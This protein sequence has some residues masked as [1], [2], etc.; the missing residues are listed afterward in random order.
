MYG[1]PYYQP[2]YSN[3]DE[4]EHYGILGMKW[5]VRRY[6]NPDGTLTQAGKK[7]YAGATQDQIDTSERRKA[8]VVKAAKT[9]AKAVAVGGIAA[10]SI[11][12]LTSGRPAGAVSLGSKALSQLL[13]SGM[14]SDKLAADLTRDNLAREGTRSL[15]WTLWNNTSPTYKSTGGTLSQ[16]ALAKVIESELK[17]NR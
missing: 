12:A 5:G 1:N 10:L 4:L 13:D 3:D 15:S 14:L 17:R 11:V 7:R 9:A 2:Y 16:E 8:K 6:Q